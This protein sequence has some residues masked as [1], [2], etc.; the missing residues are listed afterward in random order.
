MLVVYIGVILVGIVAVSSLILEVT[1]LLEDLAVRDP[2]FFQ[3][4]NQFGYF[5]NGSQSYDS[6]VVGQ[7]IVYSLGYF[8]ILNALVLIGGIVVIVI[9]P[10]SPPA[11]LNV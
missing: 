6:L 3:V 5:G 10:S 7:T 4:F 2:N 9:Q 8:G 1:K 11:M